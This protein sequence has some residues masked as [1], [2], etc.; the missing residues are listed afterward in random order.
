MGYNTVA[1]LL[2]DFMHH[3]EKS[4]KTIA[5]MVSHPPQRHEF[6]TGEWRK[7][8]EL[9]ATAFSEPIPDNQALEVLPTFH[10]DHISFFRAGA[11]CITELKVLKYGKTKDGRETV[12]LELPDWAKRR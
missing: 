4:P 10:A 6:N 1:F 11:N 3:L 5:W 7:E 12:T 2:N 9:I 8:V